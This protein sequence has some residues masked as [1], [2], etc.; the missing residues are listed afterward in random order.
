MERELKSATRNKMKNSV[1]NALV[2]NADVLIPKA[3]VENEI[4]NLKAQ[5][6]QQMG[7]SSSPDPSLL[8][9]DLFSKQAEKRVILGLLMGEI[10]EEQ[11]IKADPAKVRESVEELAST[12]ESPDEVINWYYGN[13]EQLSVIE[14]Q[15]VE[16]EIFDF[17]LTEA[18]VTEKKMGYQDAIKPEDQTTESA[19]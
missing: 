1:M 11:K 7:G 4:A 19:D 17:I 10:M 16:D 18:K 8:P 15:V 6:I 13:K 12:Y 3:L 2:E 9:D 14:S 5:A